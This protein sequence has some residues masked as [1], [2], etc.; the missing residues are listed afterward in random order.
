[1]IERFLQYLFDGLSTGAI[2]SLLALGLVIVYRGTGHLNFA[3]GE[4]A[5]LSAFMAWWLSD[6]WL[7]IWLAVFVSAIFAFVLGAVVER[8]IIRPIAKRSVFA[9]GVA[10]IGLLL[11]INAL[12]P[13]MW[14][15]THP[16]TI[17]S[18]FPK[19]PDDFVTVGG[20]HWRYENISVLVVMLAVAGFLFMLFQKT[21]L[22]LAMRAVASNPESAP[23][24]GIKTGQV[25]MISWGL[26]AAVGAVGGCM[27]ASLRGN[28]DS[29]MMLAIFFSATAAAMLGGFDSLVGAVVAGLLLGIIE[30]MAAGYQPDI[31]GQELKGSLS[32]VIILVVLLFRPSGLFGSRRVER[33]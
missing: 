4:M 14:K 7:P 22:G 15:V 6:N 12:A 25:L 33:V 31:I 26:A 8:V 32:L 5:M 28:V 3:Q 11:G 21:K 17:G 29:A 9:V 19:N 24:A 13:F 16:E 2:Y 1:M 10:A 20:A 18:L 27:V 30:N 23:L